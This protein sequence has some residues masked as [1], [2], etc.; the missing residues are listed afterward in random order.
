MKL[1]GINPFEQHVD[2]IVLGVVALAALGVVA[3][4][5]LLDPN[6]VTIGKSGPVSPALAYGP[7]ETAA[8]ELLGKV[9]EDKPELPPAPKTDVLTRFQTQLKS[10]VAPK[11]ELT[12]NLSKGCSGGR[13]ALSSGC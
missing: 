11:V 13:M 1:K 9:R 3:A 6:K 4:Q 7:V 12:A 5:F 8:N 2:K 10:G